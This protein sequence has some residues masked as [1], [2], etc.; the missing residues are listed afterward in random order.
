PSI[1]EVVG[2]ST[3]P[4]HFDYHCPLLTLPSIMKTVEKTIPSAIPYLTAD[5]KLVNEWREKLAADKNLKIGICYQG[6]DKYSTA[7]LRAAVA[8]KSLPV[9]LFEPLTQIPGVSV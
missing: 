9:M 8:A 7:F 1:D 2:L 5:P 6:N 4:A 3:V